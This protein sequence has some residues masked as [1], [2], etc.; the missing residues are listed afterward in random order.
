M[1]IMANVHL[2]VTS[3]DLGHITLDDTDSWVMVV[4][5]CLLALLSRWASVISYFAATLPGLPW[6]FDGSG[7]TC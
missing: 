1:S 3:G 4:L 6:A 5:T 7:R 2:A